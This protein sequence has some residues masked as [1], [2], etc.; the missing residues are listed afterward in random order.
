MFISNVK[1]INIASTYSCRDT[2]LDTLI[3]EYSYISDNTLH[4]IPN[5]KGHFTLKK[6][7]HPVFIILRRIPYVLKNKVEKEIECLCKYLMIVKVGNLKWETPIIPI[8]KPNGSIRLCAKY[9]VTLIK[10][11]K[12][13]I[14][15]IEDIFS[16][17]NGRKLLCI[18]DIRQAYLN[19]LITKES[20]M[21][22]TIS[23]CKGTF[24]VNRLM[25]GVIKFIANIYGPC[26]IGI[27][28]TKCFFEDMIF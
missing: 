1:K 2:E 24:K 7:S 22:Q 15:V 6:D 10:N 11:E 17:M 9:K 5:F 16:E 13:L 27:P 20:A 21:M 26:N 28:G 8:V 19:L 4:C 23:T 3:S 12:Y 18:L 14:P 25:F